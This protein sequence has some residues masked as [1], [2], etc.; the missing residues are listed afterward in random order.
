MSMIKEKARVKRGLSIAGNVLFAI[1]IA[2]LLGYALLSRFA[3]DTAARIFPYQAYAIVTDS[4]EPTITAGSMVL[5][6]RAPAGRTIEPGTI[7]TF[8]A[9]RFGQSIILTHYLARIDRIGEVEIFRTHA[10]GT[11]ELDIYETRR[12]DVLGTYVRHIPGMG[13]LAVFLNSSYALYALI[14]VLSI[15]FIGNYISGRVERDGLFVL[16]GVRF[17]ALRFN[18]SQ[19]NS[20]VI[21][22]KIKNSSKSP[23]KSIVVRVDTCRENQ[24]DSSIEWELLTADKFLLP[25]QT[26]DFTKETRRGPSGSIYRLSIAQITFGENTEFQRTWREKSN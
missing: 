24:I 11:D 7:I 5:V 4:M 2:F 1:I 6:K 22:G 20:A 16:K 10:E 19:D 12:D 9:D 21:Y 8:R 14:A 3:P 26:L 23:L 18:L 17:K 13:K 15:L 25:K